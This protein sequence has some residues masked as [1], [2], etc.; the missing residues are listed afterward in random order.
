M[1]CH[2]SLIYMLSM[3]AQSLQS[4]LTLCDPMD[5]S[6]PDS[7]LHGNSPG[8]NTGVGCHS[9]LQGIFPFQE[10]KLHLLYLLAGGFFTTSTAWEAQHVIILC[11]LLA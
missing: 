3:H 6:L 1:I 2:M 11:Q 7:S 8:K 4:C 5:C 9:L 10:W